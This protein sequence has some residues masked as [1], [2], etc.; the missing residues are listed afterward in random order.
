MLPATVVEQGDDEH[1][2]LTLVRLQVGA[3]AVLA[4]LTRRSADH[5]G[6]AAGLQ[7]WAQ[8]K[9]VAVL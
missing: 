5:L 2:A 8:I 3:H 7:V 9:A 1:P 4:R 6:L